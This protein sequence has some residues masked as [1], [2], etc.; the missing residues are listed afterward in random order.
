MSLFSWWN[1]Q[2]ISGFR[3]DFFLIFRN[4]N[5]HFWHKWS[6]ENLF[7]FQTTVEYG[8]WFHRTRTNG[9]QVFMFNSVFIQNCYLVI[10]I[11]RIASVSDIKARA[12]VFYAKP[13]QAQWRHASV[14][15]SSS[16]IK[17]LTQCL[18][19]PQAFVLIEKPLRQCWFFN[20]HFLVLTN[21]L[22]HRCTCLGNKWNPHTHFTH[23]VGCMT[24][25]VIQ[26]NNVL[27]QNI[28]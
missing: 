15:Y 6:V 23:A 9:C 10:P 13:L 11:I 2:F 28:S 3:T 27:P 7:Y 1:V 26:C 17:L 24:Q 4:L 20:T 14:G 5:F 22:P 8:G 18:R 16:L 25:T 21:G 19:S 12:T